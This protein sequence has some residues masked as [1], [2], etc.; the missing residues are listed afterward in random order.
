MWK[1]IDPKDKNT[2][3]GDPE[4]F[5]ALPKYGFKVYG[6]EGKQYP[7]LVISLISLDQD[8]QL[9]VNRKQSSSDWW[10]KSNAP[11]YLIDDMIELLQNAKIS[12]EDSDG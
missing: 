8:I 9:S 6:W 2:G 7:R 12:C 1:P 3:H 5:V 11:F 10:E 4:D